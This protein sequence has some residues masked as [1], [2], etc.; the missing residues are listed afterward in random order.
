[1]ATG[2]LA[3]VLAACTPSAVEEIKTPPPS[4]S[5]PS[6]GTSPAD[7]PAFTRPKIVADVLAAAKTAVVAVNTYDYHHFDDDLDAVRAHTTGD[8]RTQLVHA[9]DTFLRA[10][11]RAAQEVQQATVET[12]GLL[13]LGPRGVKADALVGGNLHTAKQNVN[14][15]TTAFTTVVSLTLVHGHWLA[16]GRSTPDGVGNAPSA[17][18]ALHAAYYAAKSHLAALYTLHLK[19]FDKDYDRALGYTTADAYTTLSKRR[20]AIHATLKSQQTNYQGTLSALSVS[21][22]SAGEVDVFAVLDSYSEWKGVKS[23]VR[24]RQVVATLVPTKDGWL[25]SAVSATD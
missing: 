4:P 2:A 13:A 23:A 21:A 24:H 12:V 7:A 6:S 11:A 9:Y 16:S 19:L 25:I 14:P 17:N 5:A 18:P 1:L 22:V 10:H 15:T 8:Y 20:A 3:V